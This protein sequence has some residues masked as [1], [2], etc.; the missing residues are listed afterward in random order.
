MEG[1]SLSERFY[2]TLVAPVGLDLGGEDP[3]EIGLAI[4]AELLAHR[5]G[6]SGGRLRDR[7]G[8]IHRP[9]QVL[10]QGFDLSPRLAEKRGSDD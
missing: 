9:H 8:P 5:K 10:T 1:V 3:W 7:K 4:A 6:A 2:D